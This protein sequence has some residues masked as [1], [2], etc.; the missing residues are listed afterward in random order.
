MMI[1][2]FAH[3][4]T[5]DERYMTDIVGH[6]ETIHAT[7]D[8]RTENN[9]GIRQEIE[10]SWR[11]CRDHYGLDANYPTQPTHIEPT[12]LRKRQKHHA[13]LLVIAR[14]E[15]ASIV[16]HCDGA[17]C[18]VL[19]ADTDGVV[20]ECMRDEI[21]SKSNAELITNHGPGAICREQSEGTNAIGICLAEQTEAY[22]SGKEHFFPRNTQLSA[23]AVPIFSPGNELI[24]ILSIVTKADY[25]QHNSLTLA[26]ITAQIIENQ[27]FLKVYKDNYILRFNRYKEQ[28]VTPKDALIAFDNHGHVLNFSRNTSKILG[29]ELTQSLINMRIEEV[30]EIDPVRLSDPITRY[31]YHPFEIGMLQSNDSYYAIVQPPE[32][33]SSSS[34]YLFRG[35]TGN[36]ES[37]SQG[38]FDNLEYGDARMLANIKRAQKVLDK[39]IPVLLY[40]ETGTGKGVF[41]KALHHASSRSDKPFVAVNCA[42][43]PETLIES[44]LFG[45]RPGAFTGARREG[46]RGKIVHANGGTLFLDEIGDMPPQLQARLLRVLEDKE[47]VPLGSETA[48]YVDINIISATHRTLETLIQKNI[49]R[50]DLYYRLHG[51]SL[52]MPAL[53]ERSDKFTLIQ[54]LIQS[55]NDSDEA[56]SVTPEVM[57]LLVNFAWPGNIR[58]L[59]NVIRSTRAICT[60]R[61]IRVSDLPDEIVQNFSNELNRTSQE[62]QLPQNIE[63]PVAIAERDAIISEL[64]A[65]RWNITNVA[66]K[67]GMSRNTLYRK[68]KRFGI[69]PP[70]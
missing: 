1:S 26:R 12:D 64:R 19:L 2:E 23:T 55:A 49:F 41:A 30:F 15:M 38:H 34:V 56:Y 52:T 10:R 43:I 61:I 63:N 4:E 51:I 70:R 44:E 18:M 11:R 40:G 27:Y 54:N 37:P 9:L 42:S 53:R 65:F 69:T 46:S 8:G 28:V 6:M 7:L 48:I 21:L 24:A 22:V 47:V 68:M 14:L 60:D 66:K 39:D 33:I 36:A 62:Q 45:Y 67:L 35:T 29:D 16:E 32:S 5:T 31:T 17:G 13:R 58:Q 50:E 57:Q 3:S 25:I 59:C 20:L